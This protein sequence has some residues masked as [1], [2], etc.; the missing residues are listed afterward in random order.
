MKK[1]LFFSLLSMSLFVACQSYDAGPSMPDEDDLVVAVAAAEEIRQITADVNSG[2][3]KNILSSLFGNHC[4]GRSAD[5]TVSLLKD[6]QGIDRVI[7]VNYADNGGFALISAEKTH[8]PILAYAEE[9]N[10]IFGENAPAALQDWMNY[11]MCDIADSKSLPVDSL[12]KIAIQW[13]RYEDIPNPLAYDNPED[14]SQLKNMTWEEFMECSRKMMDSINIWNSNGYR[15]YAIDDYSGTTSLGD[16]NALASYVQ[17]RI[18]PYYMEDYWAVTLIVEKEFDKGY[19]KSSVIR[20]D[21]EQENGFNEV[22]YGFNYNANDAIQYPVGC[23]AIALGQIMYYYRYPTTFNWDSMVLKGPGNTATSNFL[24]D[25]RTKIQSEFDKFEVVTHTYPNKL[26][27]G[28]LA[29]GYQCDIIQ[30]SDMTSV[31]LVEK[32][33][34]I[35]LSFLNGNKDEGHA[36]VLDGG[37]GGTTDTY[38]EIWSFDYNK[39]FVKF[40]TDETHSSFRFYYINWGWGKNNGYYTNLVPKGYNSNTLYLAYRIKPNI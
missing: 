34:L 30:P 32:S 6:K 27:N 4:K 28:I 35:M 38:T 40:H 12:A 5:Y 22:F 16:K 37:G 31:N 36:W 13:R 14:H 7:C 23:G 3:V 29:Y 18:Y 2:E 11:T 10:F 24:Y 17:G 25:V 33:P 21:W 15:V 26:Y 8:T 9:G 39:D 1:Q 20:T 19:G